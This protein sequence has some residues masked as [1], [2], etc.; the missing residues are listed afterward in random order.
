MGVPRRS[1]VPGDDRLAP[2]DAAIN[3][4]MR[5]GVRRQS[6]DL[7]DDRLAPIDAAVNQTM[8]RGGPEAI[9]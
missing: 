8:R 3:Q 1:V 6:I 4:R 9:D 2:I 5:R 7:G